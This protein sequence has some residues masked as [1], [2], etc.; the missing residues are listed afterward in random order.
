MA[1]SQFCCQLCISPAVSILGDFKFRF[2]PKFEGIK[3]DQ[4][5]ILRLFR[6]VYK[7]QAW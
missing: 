1:V 2:L 4:C 7:R 3:G 6:D 5:S